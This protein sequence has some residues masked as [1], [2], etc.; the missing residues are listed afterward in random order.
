MAGEKEAKLRAVF[1]RFNGAGE[2]GLENFDPQIE[3][4]LRADLPDSRTLRGHEQVEQLYA[5]WSEAFED[6][7]IEPV[8][9]S[10]VADRTIV[11]VHVH[12]SVKGSGQEVDMDEVW[13]YSWRGEKVIELREYRTKDEA[14]KSLGSSVEQ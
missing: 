5:E 8:E 6:L 12:G 9:V 11:A 3:W 1:E 14:L 10:E 2:L 4:H 13:V 7:Q